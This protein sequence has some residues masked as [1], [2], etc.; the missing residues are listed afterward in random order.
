MTG[1]VHMSLTAVAEAHQTYG[2]DSNELHLPTILCYCACAYT[3]KWSGLYAHRAGTHLY[4]E[5]GH[6]VAVVHVK[7]SNRQVS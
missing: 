6:R 7:V 2:E 4:E 1:A 5:V 3:L